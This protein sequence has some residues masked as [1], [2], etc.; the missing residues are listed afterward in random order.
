MFRDRSAL[1]RK[2]P[3]MIRL[4]GRMVGEGAGQLCFRLGLGR[5]GVHLQVRLEA[6]RFGS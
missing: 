2:G 1:V 6:W 3:D 5:G 4:G